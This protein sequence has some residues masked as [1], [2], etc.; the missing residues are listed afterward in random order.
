M[1][2]YCTQCHNST[3]WAGGVAFDIQ[4]AQQVPAHAKVWEN[5][6]RKLTGGFMPPPNAK[7]HPDAATVQGLTTWLERTLDT[8]EVAPYA[9]TIPLHRLDRREYKNAIRDLLG[10]NVN[11]AS[12]LPSD[13]QKDGF[14]DI[15]STLEI[16]PSFVDQYVSAARKVAE[17]AVGNPKAPAVTTTYG[18]VAYMVIS[19][20][21]RGSDGAGTQEHYQ[22][23]MP[24]GT[25]GGISFLHN[26]PADGEY[27]LSIGD[28]ALGRSVP[29]MEFR[30][31]VVALLDGKEIY[32]TIIGGPADDKGIDEQ[33]QVAVDA[34]NARL[35][36]IRFHATQGQHRIA[37]T[38]IQRSLA[39]SDSRMRSS[40]LD[41]GEPSDQS[42]YALQIR[43]PLKVTGMSDSPSR[44]KIFIC[45]PKQPQQDEPCAR[46]I[47]ANLAQRAFRRPVAD[48]DLRPLM[49]FYEAGQ[50][51]GGFETGVR[52]ALSAI[53]ASPFF[54]YRGAESL[55]TV[56]DT[57][58]ISDLELA[59]RLSFFL[60]SS[61]PDQQLLT[62]A[63]HHELHEPAV[64][65]QQVRRMFA[66]PRSKA[67]VTGFAFQW[68]DV[69]ALD[70]IVPDRRLF[71]DA[72]GTQ[73][74]RP[75]YREELRLFLNS[76]LRSNQPVTA[77]LTADYTYLN[78]PLAE[79]YGIS[80]VKGAQFRRVALRDEPYRDGLLGKG[81]ILMLSSNPDRTSPT[82]RGAWILEH[83]YGSPPPT[84]PPNVG[85]LP[86]TPRGKPATM[87]E[88]MRLH[89]INPTCDSC[90]G[91][92]D[93]L[94]FSLANFNAVGQYHVRDPIT[95]AL[96]DSSGQLPNRMKIAG[97]AGL[98]NALASH[99]TTFLTTLTKN[100]MAYA[101]GRK[102]TYHDM[103]TI[104]RIVK[105][106][107][108][109]YRFADIVLQVV[110]SH[111][112]RRR[113]AV[114][115]AHAPAQKTASLVTPPSRATGSV[116]ATD[117]PPRQHNPSLVETSLE[118]GGN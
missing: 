73:D 104:R 96:I 112:F 83:L 3:D 32:R 42:A 66:D 84:P 2:H 29:H 15:A 110:M 75:L 56:S 79:L 70:E 25:R 86:N 46:K 118:N 26:F 47:I 34:I 64:L 24:F 40:A 55:E 52:D 45:Y 100:L 106:V 117:R 99:P 107:A 101:L 18:N 85:K 68:L 94:G 41:G 113:D 31:T 20:E 19:L 43:G 1:Q 103:P 50:R 21:P 58:T 88:R 27:Q 72:S 6:I 95:H 14:D 60:W 61:L 17:L 49:A 65:A 8:S 109:H 80:D 38:F 116:P 105:S 7:Q 57:G 11:V 4:T 67:L 87:R 81:A 63:E 82:R 35:K 48:Q 23:G 37:V 53:L 28:M 5:A 10:L 71:Q 108:P 77:L 92:I 22:P 69:A 78:E 76:V 30:N 89:A 111:E 12:L 13:A 51:S 33:Q 102:V 9:G 16:S 74:P 114:A 59:T 39:E 54:L 98:R 36:N 90:H 93:P 62:L 97:P 115:P 91:V 44:A